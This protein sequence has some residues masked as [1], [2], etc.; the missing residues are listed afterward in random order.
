[1]KHIL[2]T[3]SMLRR[4]LSLVLALCL[5]AALAPMPRV[6]A[7]FYD[8][9]VQNLIGW[10]V[11]SGYP[12]GTFQPQ[13]PIT[14][15]EF[16]AMINRAYG[17]TKVGATPFTDVPANAWYA[18]DI[19]IAYN[20]G[21][22][23][24]TS[25]TTASPTAPLTREQALVLLAKNMRMDDTAGEVIGFS[26]GKSFSTW[27]QG[28]ANSAVEKGLVGGYADG[29]Y[30]PNN[31]ITRGE[32]AVLL[33]RALGNLVHSAGPY[34]LGDVYGN[35]SINSPGT[36]LK[37]TTIAGDLYIS[38]GLDQEGVTLENVRVLGEIIVAGSGE[39]QG[40]DSVL[41]FNTRAEKLKVDNI[42]NQYLSLRAEAT[43]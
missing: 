12:D 9:A 29:S 10:G 25:S 31:N 32:M 27:S 37:D 35:V 38:G 22:F 34:T 41:L 36:T 42:A 17:Y 20:A 14:R 6:S 26:D 28:Y 11:M 2:S 8:D 16:V 30:R 7:E 21:Y 24:G 19:G 40:G 1:M 13:N 23:S 43:L 15:A 3:R 4:C 33:N 39:A 18:N 5:F